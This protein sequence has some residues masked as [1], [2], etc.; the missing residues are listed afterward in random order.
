MV[1]GVNAGWCRPQAFAEAADLQT[2]SDQQVAVA[3]L[4]LFLAAR[5]SDLLALPRAA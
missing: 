4:L 3:L 5:R 1:V 2:I